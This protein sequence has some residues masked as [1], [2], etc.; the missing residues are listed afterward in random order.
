MDAIKAI[1]ERRSI[2]TFKDEVV[3]K[4]TMK[5][6]IDISRWAPS[7]ANY[8]VA[9][10]TLINDPE[11]IDRIKNNGVN[12]FIY[13]S[14]VLNNAKNVAILS[15][16]KGKSGK[17][18]NRNMEGS[19]FNY[20]GTSNSWEVFDSGIA[21]QTFCLAAHAKGIG[22]VIMGVINDK[23]ISDIIDLPKDETVA[24]MIVYGYP[25]GDHPKASPRKEV[26][27][28]LRFI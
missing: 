16:V 23:V 5:E 15:F 3:D 22:T 27:E 17:I 18:E 11:T 1:K 13:N 20:D 8:Q 24:A 4:E 25:E 12:D 26:E 21:C 19:I 9:R 2:R 14:A 28:I 10:Y 7:W 6:I